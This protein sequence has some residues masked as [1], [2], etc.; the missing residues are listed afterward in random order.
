MDVI[1][2]DLDLLVIVTLR[3]PVELT[4]Y[5]EVAG[6]LE[7]GAQHKLQRLIHR[8]VE[9]QLDDI[10]QRPHQDHDHAQAFH[11][12]FLV[13][14][15]QLRQRQKGFADGAQCAD[16]LRHVLATPERVN[17]SDADS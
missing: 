10:T 12:L 5:G 13:V 7:G 17:Q 1:H 15:P 14:T 3:V 16:A 9:S 8:E 6:Y 11:A 2:Q 4:Q